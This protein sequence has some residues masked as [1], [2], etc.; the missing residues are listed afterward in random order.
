LFHRRSFFHQQ[1]IFVIRNG[2][3]VFH[4][5]AEAGRYR[6]QVQLGPGIFGAE[7]IFESAEDTGGVFKRIGQFLP[8]AAR[9]QSAQR[10][11]AFADGVGRDFT[12]VDQ[13]IG[14]NRKRQKVGGER[15]GGFELVTRVAVTQV[16]GSAF[17]PVRDG[18]V[19]G[20]ADDRDVEGNLEAGLIKT[21]KYL[22]GRYGF[23]L[24]NGIPIRTAL[25]PEQGVETIVE[26]RRPRH[27]QRQ[28]SGSGR[29]IQFY[30]CDTGGVPLLVVYSRALAASVIDPGIGNVE[31]LAV[32]PESGHAFRGLEV[33]G[34]G[35]AEPLFA[36][37]D[38]EFE[39]VPGRR[40]WLIEL[41]C[42]RLQVRFGSNLF[43]RLG[44]RFRRF[45]LCRF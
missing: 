5:S 15:S 34:H 41:A 22:P 29:L 28:S 39:P 30:S 9:G 36:R 38:A 19:T 11:S 18:D 33:D 44:S 40:H 32:K 3:R 6:N 10:Q 8:L 14:P 31:P 27:V 25:Y 13:V 43:C 17:R 45:G 20:P 4:G 26:S 1:Q 35:A 7:V 23:E 12:M 2:T 16:D 24:S 37:V 42:R 21:G